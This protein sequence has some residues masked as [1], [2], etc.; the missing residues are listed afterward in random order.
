MADDN[1]QNT[2]S[3]SKTVGT[4]TQETFTPDKYITVLGS[5]A[6]T[7]CQADVSPQVPASICV[8]QAI[9][10]CGFDPNT[11]FFKESDGRIN[12]NI[13]NVRGSG[14]ETGF[15]YCS[16]FSEA[17]NLYYTNMHG[18]YYE[19]A[20]ACLKPKIVDSTTEDKMNYLQALIPVYAPSSENNVPQYILD[21][22]GF[23]NDYDLFKWDD[24]SLA[25]HTIDDAWIKQ[26]AAAAANGTLNNGGSAKSSDG[27][28]R[29]IEHGKT[30]TIIKLPDNKTFCEPIYPD[31]I[32]VS[33]TVPQWVLDMSYQHKAEENAKASKDKEETNKDDSNNKEDANKDNSSDKEDTNKDDSNNKETQK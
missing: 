5:I 29:Y 18:G 21:V 31:F 9:K 10:E 15:A 8:A 16:S 17:V 6:A 30:V 7:R 23:I 32:T 33:D 20:L 24:P 27:G 4:V 1:K 25:G 13:F 3:Q 22:T 19:S 2:F 11:I 26:M 28:F 12:Y 14:S